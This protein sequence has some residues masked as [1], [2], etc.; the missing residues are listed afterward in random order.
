MKEGAREGSAANP[1]SNWSDG[2]CWGSRD[3]SPRRARGFGGGREQPTE[4]A[5]PSTFRNGKRWNRCGAALERTGVSRIA[6]ATRKSKMTLLEGQREALTRPEDGQ[7]T[8]VVS[9]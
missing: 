3:F 8:D 6:V 4:Q 1:W 2:W 5:H 9:V 7:T